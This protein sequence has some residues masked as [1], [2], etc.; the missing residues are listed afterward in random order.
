MSVTTREVPYEVPTK[1][2]FPTREEFEGVWRALA[3]V[4]EFGLEPL[5]RRIAVPLV[6][7]Y[8]STFEA[9]VPF[10]YEDL[11]ILTAK[12]DALIEWAE[13]VSEH[14]TNLRTIAHD[15]GNAL[16]ANGMVECPP[17]FG[18]FG[19]EYT[20]SAELLERWGLAT[21]KGGES[22]AS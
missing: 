2:G 14:A 8:E 10:T 3:D 16:E 21:Q 13:L 20:P 1:G 18:K 4:R 5:L 15:V 7:A 17:A 22:D 9:T 11:G 6:D 19:G 12:A